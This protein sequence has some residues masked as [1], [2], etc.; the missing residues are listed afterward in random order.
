MAVKNNTKICTSAG[1]AACRC[2][3]VKGEKKPLYQKRM[4]PETVSVVNVCCW[5]GWDGEGGGGGGGQ[6][7]LMPA[8]VRMPVC[9]Q[10][11]HKRCAYL[12]HAYAYIFK[13]MYMYMSVHLCVYVY[14]C[15]CLCVCQC[16]YGSE[17]T[18]MYLCMSAHMIMYLDEP[19]VLC[20][21]H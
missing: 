7:F 10:C 21:M 4:S 14:V 9:R 18:H 13:H 3:R 6:V 12:T 11:V 15:T 20:F 2:A 16:T 8:P 5:G 1:S 19:C 17:H